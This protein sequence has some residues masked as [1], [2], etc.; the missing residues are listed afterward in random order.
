M[1]NI[2]A[3]CKFLTEV[4]EHYQQSAPTV[5]AWADD[6]YQRIS[7]A[8]EKVVLSEILAVQH[9]LENGEWEQ[10]N[11]ATNRIYHLMHRLGQDT[12]GHAGF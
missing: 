3:I 8:P 11:M 9:L 4:C 2:H 12:T 1:I 7:D 10:A 5:T 6:L